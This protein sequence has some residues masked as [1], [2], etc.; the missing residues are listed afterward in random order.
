MTTDHTVTVEVRTEGRHTKYMWT[1]SC[2][3]HGNLKPAPAQA[4]IGGNSHLHRQQV[5]ASS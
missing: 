4:Q 5:R 2:G 1:C 3:K